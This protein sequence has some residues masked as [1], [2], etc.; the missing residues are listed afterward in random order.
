MVYNRYMY[1]HVHMYALSLVAQMHVHASG[2]F[3]Q[4]EGVHWAWISCSVA[5]AELVEEGFLV[6]YIARESCDNFGHAHFNS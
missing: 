6:K 3:A 2:L 4:E 5:D 1:M